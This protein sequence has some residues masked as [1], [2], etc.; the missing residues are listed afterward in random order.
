M[1]RSEVITPRPRELEPP[2][3]HDGL[4]WKIWLSRL[5]LPA[6]AVADELG[7]FAALARCPASVLSLAGQLEISSRGA[8]AL[9][10][11]LAGLGLVRQLAGLFHI[12]E[13]ARAFLLPDGPYYW[14]A[15]FR[16]FCSAPERI[17][18]SALLDALREHPD[19]DARRASTEWTGSQLPAERAR[20]ISDYMHAH[21]VTSAAGLARRV[22]LSD[23]SHVLDVG[24]GSGCFSIALTRRYPQLRCT[25]FDLP[26]VAE[27]VASR[28]AAE[29]VSARVAVRGGDFFVDSW[30]TGHDVVLLSN[31]LHDW[32]EERCVELLRRAYVSL[33]RSGRVLVHEMLLDDGADHDLDAASFSLQMVI[34][35]RGKQLTAAALRDMLARAGFVSISFVNSLGNFWTAQA[36]K[37]DRGG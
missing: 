35:T 25:I 30:P 36:E 5:H 28:A 13:M 29:G 34:G 12:T 20:L 37:Q 14:G 23:A 27:L 15:V 1:S 26:P 7:L 16:A 31:I 18:P 10:G 21:S 33:P 17:H 22:D 2:P 24:G 8:E 3:V 4:L 9:L 19:A 11:V 6:V 32:E